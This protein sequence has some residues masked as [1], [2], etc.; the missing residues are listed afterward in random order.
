MARPRKQGLDYFPVDTEMDYKMD[1]IQELHG[2]TGFGVVMRLFQVIYSKGYYMSWGKI[3]Q[4]LTKKKIGLELELIEKII[5][6]CVEVGIFS[7]KH[8]EE[9]EILT[10][11]GIQKRYYEVVKKREEVELNP[12][13]IVFDKLLP[14]KLDIPEVS[15]EF[16]TQK[17][18]GNSEDIPTRAEKAKNSIVK[19]SKEIAEDSIALTADAPDADNSVYSYLEKEFGRTISPSEFDRL[20]V[21][22]E[23]MPDELVREAIARAALNNVTTIPYVIAILRKWSD[24]GI[25]NLAG[26]YAADAQHKGSKGKRKAADEKFKAN[27][28]RGKPVNKS[29]SSK[30]KPKHK[31]TYSGK[32]PNYYAIYDELEKEKN[33]KETNYDPTN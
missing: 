15:V 4:V 2:I 26:V 18:V 33:S 7:K 23:N 31:A 8:F 10:S 19:N 13:F 25:I 20:S 27:K 11:N 14:N 6:D 21:Y 3:E 5:K 12:E 29:G 1:Y 17:P 22:A 28:A 24:A 30:P 9:Y 32:R 16:P